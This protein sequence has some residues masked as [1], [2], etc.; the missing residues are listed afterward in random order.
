[1]LIT[2][3]LNDDPRFKTYKVANVRSE[4]L[5]PAEFETGELSAAQRGP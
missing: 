4:R 2:V 1:M 5:L 3:K